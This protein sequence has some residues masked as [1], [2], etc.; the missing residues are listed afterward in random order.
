MIIGKKKLEQ[1][2]TKAQND[3]R[4]EFYERQSINNIWESIS[5]GNRSIFKIKDRLKIIEERLEVL[6]RAMIEKG[7]K[8]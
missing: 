7:G 6:E 5:K 4:T 3:V 8:R 1:L 2:I